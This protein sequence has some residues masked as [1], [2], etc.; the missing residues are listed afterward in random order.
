M[1]MRVLFVSVLGGVNL[2]GLGFALGLQEIPWCAF[3]LLVLRGYYSGGSGDGVWRWIFQFVCLLR[4][5]NGEEGAYR[6]NDKL[7]GN[8]IGI[9]VSS[10]VFG[11]FNKYTLP[12]V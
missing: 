3:A 11:H 6:V 2:G 9:L 12:E 10:C 4:V 5:G 7:D 1:E 8:S